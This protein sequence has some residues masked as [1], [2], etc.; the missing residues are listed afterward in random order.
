MTFARSG[1]PLAGRRPAP[2]DACEKPE[3]IERF[4]TEARA[5]NL[6]RHEGIVRVLDFTQFATGR[7]AIATVTVAHRGPPGGSR[8]R[9][10]SIPPIEATR[11]PPGAPGSSAGSAP[12]SSATAAPAL[13]S[14]GGGSSATAAPAVTSTVPDRV[15]QPID[16]DLHHFDPSAYFPRARS[17]ARTLVPDAELTMMLFSSVASD[18]FVDFDFMSQEQISYM[19]RSPSRSTRPAGVPRNAPLPRDCGVVVMVS[20]DSVAAM[21]SAQ[22][23][24][25]APLARR[26]VPRTMSGASRSPA[27]PRAISSRTWRGC[28]AG[29]LRRAAPGG[30]SIR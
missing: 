28:T 11:A 7:P 8:A 27:E 6:I 23:C 20:N 17:L 10:R 1:A 30:T 19:F 14:S 25:Y 24:E 15:V 21:P 4:F 29:L 12:G 16:L 13:S 9:R 26:A 18:G 3:L 22:S 5:V 2:D